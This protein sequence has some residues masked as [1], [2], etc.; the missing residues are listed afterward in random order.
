MFQCVAALAEL[1]NYF[2]LVDASAWSAAE[3][4]NDLV[5][6]SRLPFD[7]QNGPVVR[8]TLYRN[9][10]DEHTLLFRAHHIAVDLWSL[11]VFIKEFQAAYEALEARREPS[12]NSQDARYRDFVAWQRSYPDTAPGLSDWEYWRERLAGE[13]PI[14]NLPADYPRPISPTY[15]GASQVLR[16]SPGLTAQLKKLGARHGATLFMSLL[17]AYKVLLY[18]HTHQTDLI[19]GV[20]SSGRTQERFAQTVG[21]FVNPIALR[22]RLAPAVSF[23]DYLCQVRDTV[24]GALAHQDFPFPLLVERLHPQRIGDQWPIYQT[25]FVF[26]QAQAGVERGL[27]QLALGE[28]STPQTWGDWSVQTLRLPEHVENFD[29]KL[30]AVESEQGLLV[31]FQYRRDL[32]APETIARMARHYEVLLQGIVAT[33]EQRVAD[34]RMLDAAEHQGLVHGWNATEID[35][36]CDG[37][38]HALIEVQ[39]RRTPQAPALQ[40]FYKTY[41]YQEVIELSNRIAHKLL[42]RGA[43]P[44]TIIGICARRSVELVLGLLG[45]MKA[46]APTCPWTPTIPRNAW[47]RSWRTPGRAGS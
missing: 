17:A 16:L 10:M 3:F 20:P 26:Q 41:N 9:S 30:M 44:D 40:A 1:K 4:E 19:V 33:P 2:E 28:S 43:G 47:R 25:W 14:L 36:G 11:L 24:C 37:F 42:A 39:A 22:T 21:Y 38:V 18:R 23:S 15:R 5:H 12:F 6:R 27:A 34:L 29:L 32:V 31:S 13:L 7:L 35:Y 45:I 46:G 8:V